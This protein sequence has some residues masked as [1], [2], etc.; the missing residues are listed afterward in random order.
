MTQSSILPQAS[1]PS[2]PPQLSSAPSAPPLPVSGLTDGTSDNVIDAISTFLGS[3]VLMPT[4][5]KALVKVIMALVTEDASSHV[6]TELSSKANPSSSGFKLTG[7]PANEFVPDS[8]S[9]AIY[10]TLGSYNAKSPS[11]VMIEESHETFTKV[12][13]AMADECFLYYYQ[14]MLYNMPAVPSPS[15]PYYCVTRGCYVGVFNGW[16]NVA[17][18]VQG[19][20]CAIFSKVELLEAGEEKLRKAIEQGKVTKV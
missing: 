15:P 12:A 18:K 14:G 1:T 11:V 2:A 19:I 10:V 9:L 7:I 16:D 13:N 20:P 6:K 3:L 4:Q 17:P 5:A 8:N